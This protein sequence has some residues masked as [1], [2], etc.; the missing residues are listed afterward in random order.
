MRWMQIGTVNMVVCLSLTED[1]SLPRLGSF[2][3][4]FSNSPFFNGL[5]DAYFFL[6]RIVSRPTA[7]KGKRK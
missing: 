4:S 3:V 1:C 6:R 7:P 5:L 2:P